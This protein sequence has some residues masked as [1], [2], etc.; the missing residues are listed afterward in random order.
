MIVVLVVVNGKAHDRLAAA[1]EPNLRAVPRGCCK[2]LLRLA[3]FRNQLFRMRRR[4]RD[5]RK[6]ARSKAGFVRGEAIR[7][8]SPD[9]A[10]AY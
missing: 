8:E 1:H 4:A 3:R 6:K 2:D 10:F 7:R 9:R 5:M